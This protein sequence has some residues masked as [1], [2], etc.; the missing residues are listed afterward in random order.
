MVCIPRDLRRRSRSKHFQ[1]TVARRYWADPRFGSK[2]RTAACLASW[3]PTWPAVLGACAKIKRGVA[4]ARDGQHVLMCCTFLLY[5]R[6]DGR[7]PK[8][9]LK[10]CRGANSWCFLLCRRTACL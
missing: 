5:L 2:N 6:D 9:L 10:V 7:Y 1:Q 3:W 4:I 8:V